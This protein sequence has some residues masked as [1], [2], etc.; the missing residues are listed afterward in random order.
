MLSI[1]LRLSTEDF[2]EEMLKM[3]LPIIE[4][5]SHILPNN[6]PNYLHAVQSYDINVLQEIYSVILRIYK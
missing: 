5:Q 1:V 3:N 6:N 4:Y 2:K